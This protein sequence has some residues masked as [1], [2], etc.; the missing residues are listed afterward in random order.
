MERRPSRGHGDEE[1]ARGNGLARVAQDE[2]LPWD[3]RQRSHPPTMDIYRGQACCSRFV[4]RDRA[5]GAYA[6]HVEMVEGGA[7][8]RFSRLQ[9][10]RE[11]PNHLLGLLD[12]AAPR[13]ACLSAAAL[14]GDSR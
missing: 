5:T 4:A 11:R 14:G 10:E 8:R 6:R 13:R 2:W 12:T 9:P 3:A 1:A 7:P